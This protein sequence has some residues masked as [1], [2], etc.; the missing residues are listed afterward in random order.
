MAGLTR[1]AVRYRPCRPS[2]AAFPV[3]Y[4]AAM[5]DGRFA[6]L[7]GLPV[8]G[9][10]AVPAARHQAGLGSVKVEALLQLAAY[11]DAAGQPRACRSPT[12]VELVLGDGVGRELPRRRAAAGRKTCRARAALQR[13]L[14]EPSGRRGRGVLGRRGG[15][16]LL[17]LPRSASVQVR[18]HDDLLL[19]AGMRTSQRARLHRRRASTHRARTGRPCTGPVPE[20]SKGGAPVDALTAA[21]PAADRRT[22]RRQAAAPRWSTRS[23]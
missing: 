1:A 2:I 15:A 16:G 17:P 8:V 9:R 4:Q 7:R 10:R 3:I 5:F 13:L 23:R 14:D 21:G 11:A 6:G 22:G 20:L 18:E 12:R 19:V